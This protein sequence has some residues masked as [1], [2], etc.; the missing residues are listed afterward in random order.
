[1]PE[2]AV[3]TRFTL[4]GNA[5]ERSI[6]LAPL[7]DNSQP[8]GIW[9]EVPEDF[10]MLYLEGELVRGQG[11]KRALM[12]PPLVPGKP[13]SLRL[14][15]TSI[16][17]TNFVVEDRQVVIQAGQVVSVTFDGSSPLVVPMSQ[18]VPEMP[19]AK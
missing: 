19:P 8:A 10:S 16:I 15:A 7:F 9:V 11:K 6:N 13:C 17:G 3:V 4:P 12:S 2:G 18:L 14:R 1:M 5:Q